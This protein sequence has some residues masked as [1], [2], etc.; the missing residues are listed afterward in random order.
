[1][2]DRN[3]IRKLL[4]FIESS[5]TRDRFEVF[6]INIEV[7]KNTTIFCYNETKTLKYIRS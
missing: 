6:T 1:M 7:R 2:I 4:S 3:N 5:Y